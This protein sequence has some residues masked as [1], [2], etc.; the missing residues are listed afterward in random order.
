[1][2]VLAL[3]LRI[4]AHTRD[5][6]VAHALRKA[7]PSVF[8]YA[9][10]FAVIGLYWIAHHRMF[11]YIRRL[12]ATLLLLNL[13]VLCVVAFVPFPT[14][15]LG[16]HGNTTAA[17]VLYAGTMGVLGAVMAAFW[18]YATHGRQLVAPDTPGPFVEH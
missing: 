6:G 9:L 10:S 16:D 15:V 7:M 8:T 2:T 3:S 5:A 4:P 14:S 17:V 13:A 18:V 12:D 11:R 1:M